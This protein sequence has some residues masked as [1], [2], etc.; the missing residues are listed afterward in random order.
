MHSTMPMGM[1][2]ALGSARHQW[3]Q[4]AAAHTPRASAKATQ[5]SQND[6]PVCV[7]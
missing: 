5:N 3:N 1:H 2:T 7:L 4:I 6:V